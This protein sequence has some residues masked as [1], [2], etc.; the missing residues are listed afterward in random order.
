MASPI[1]SY[2]VI[3]YTIDEEDSNN[4]KY[5]ICQRKHSFGYMDFMKGK[6]SILNVHVLVNEM[7]ISE[8]EKICNNVPFDEQWKHLWNYQ[9]IGQFASNKYYMKAHKHYHRYYSYVLE[10]IKTSSTHWH[11]CEWEFPKGRIHPHESHLSCSLREFTEETGIPSSDIHV[12]RNVFPFQE[13]FIG[14]NYKQYIY[15]YYLAYMGPNKYKTCNLTNYQPTE[16]SDIQWLSFNECQ[17][18]IRPISIEKKTL[19]E[20]IHSIVKEYRL[21]K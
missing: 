14:S 9:D 20:N 11:E 5:L 3:V 4:I 6:Y 12:I 2:G 8:K 17:S 13:K 16:I 18:K 10:V 21:Y 7:T 1:I 15:Q 19:L